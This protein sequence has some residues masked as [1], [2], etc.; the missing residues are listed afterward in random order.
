[1]TLYKPATAY[2]DTIKRPLCKQCGAKMMLARIQ[3]DSPG[4]EQHSF[5]CPAC[6]HGFSEI[7][8]TPCK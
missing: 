8:E 4:R 6:N 3:P 2:S 5:E 1:M 7:V